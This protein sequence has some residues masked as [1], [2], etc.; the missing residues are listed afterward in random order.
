MRQ[1]ADKPPVELYEKTVCRVEVGCTESEK[2]LWQAVFGQQNL[3]S[4]ARRLLNS[5]ARRRARLPVA[6]GQ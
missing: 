5:A 6:P 2:L 1:R 4:V 3:S